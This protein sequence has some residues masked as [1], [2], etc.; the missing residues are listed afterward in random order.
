MQIVDIFVEELQERLKTKRITLELSPEARAFLAREGYS[1]EFG[2]RPLRRA[3]RKYLEE[4]LS[5]ALL[6]GTIKPDTVIRVEQEEDR[7]LFLPKNEPIKS[8]S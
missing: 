4:P 3:I 7:L 2:A 8:Q 6:A 1:P 5:E